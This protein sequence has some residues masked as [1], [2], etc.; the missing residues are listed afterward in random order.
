MSL[1]PTPIQLELVGLV[2]QPDPA[3]QDA[4]M[5]QVS[6]QTGET[7]QTLK[8]SG[9]WLFYRGDAGRVAPVRVG[10]RG[11]FDNALLRALAEATGRAVVLAVPF[12]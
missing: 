3:T 12:A 8:L 5:A 10:Q 2:P 7:W 6:A 9:C 1:T 4:L 11:R